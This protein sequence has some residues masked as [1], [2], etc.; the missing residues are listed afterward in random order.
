MKR[1]LLIIACTVMML[2]ISSFSQAQQTIFN[3]PSADATDKGKIYLG[4][5][6]QFR[7]NNPGR[8]WY[9]TD[10]FAYGLGN[11]TDLEATLYNTSWPVSGNVSLGVG[12]K[13]TFPLLIGNHSKA[14]LCLTV[15]SQALFSLQGN[16]IGVW[17]YSHLSG[18]IPKTKTRLT[19]GISVGHKQ[20]FGKNTVH[21]I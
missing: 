8:Y 18:K 21:F 7:L 11:Q 16:G 10:Y 17:G 3:I 15:G 12:F 2:F 20:L 13:S 19:A 4:H 6:S 1:L 5:A 14:E 9:V